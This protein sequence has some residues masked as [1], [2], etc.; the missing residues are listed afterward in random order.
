MEPTQ[1]EPTPKK[2]DKAKPPKGKVAGAA[3]KKI[4]PDSAKLLMQLKEKANKKDF[5]R[6]VHDKDI[7]ALGLK[8]IGDEHIKELQAGTLTER[9]K[10]TM[11]HEDFQKANGKLTLDQFIGRLLRGEIKNI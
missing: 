4:G 7:L 3:I 1:P 6:K 9:D 2:P 8:L 5:G 11:A 10:L